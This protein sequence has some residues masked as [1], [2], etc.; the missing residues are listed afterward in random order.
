MIKPDKELWD[1]VGFNTEKYEYVS[2]PSEVSKI[3]KRKKGN[4]VLLSY[5]YYDNDKD[6]K[7]MMLRELLL[8]WKKK[9]KR[10]N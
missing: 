9:L 10:Q 7:V 2:L 5:Y 4:N 3:I 8:D 6:E 1:K